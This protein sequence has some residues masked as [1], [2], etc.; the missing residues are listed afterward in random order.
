MADALDILLIA[1]DKVRKAHDVTIL[2]GGGAWKRHLEPAVNELQ[3]VAGKIRKRRLQSSDTDFRVKVACALYEMFE[4][5]TSRD[6]DDVGDADGPYPD[7]HEH[8][9][10]CADELIE[11][12][13]G[14]DPSIRKE[15][16]LYMSGPAEGIDLQAYTDGPSAS[17]EELHPVEGDVVVVKNVRGDIIRRFWADTSEEYI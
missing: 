4:M 12:I 2:N 7:M 13:T 1:A 17:L 8:W 6:W 16:L 11:K 14:K 3:K 9:L 15:Q 5:R 10:G